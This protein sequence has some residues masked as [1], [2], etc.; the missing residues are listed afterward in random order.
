MVEASGAHWG[1]PGAGRGEAHRLPL[2]ACSEACLASPGADQRRRAGLQRQLLGGG[3]HLG[4]SLCAR[5]LR[6]S[7]PAGTYPTARRRP[8]CRLHLNKRG[9]R[10]SDTSARNSNPRGEPDYDTP[11]APPPWWVGP[12]TRPQLGWVGVCA[13]VPGQVRCV[14]ERAGRPASED[15]QVL[16]GGACRDPRPQT[17]RLAGVRP[18][19]RSLNSG[20]GE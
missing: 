13:S 2:G 12:F 10:A 11:R 14:G 19:V 15:H 6:W 16:L 8:H 5:P 3:Y 20:R 17:P 4:C 18:H 1:C 7:L 9:N